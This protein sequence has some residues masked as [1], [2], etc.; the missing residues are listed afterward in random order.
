[1]KV[2]QQNALSAVAKIIL[3]T[4]AITSFALCLYFSSSI[5]NVALSAPD[6][7]SVQALSLNSYN[8]NL[9]ATVNMNSRST[10][11]RMDF[12]LNGTFIGSYNYLGNLTINGMFVMMTTRSAGA[13]TIRFSFSSITMPMMSRISMVMSRTYAIRMV[14]FFRD[15][16]NCSATSFVRLSLNGMAGMMR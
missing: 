5:W 3:I 15:G 2:R 10:L 6:S 9:S 8:S 7:L 1:L 12:Y 13:Y 4:G 14:A 11:D 16:T